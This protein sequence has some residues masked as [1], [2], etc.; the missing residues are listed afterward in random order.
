[1]KDIELLPCPF[2][3]GKADIIMDSRTY[4]MNPN[5]KVNAY[6]P[7]CRNRNCIIYNLGS[8]IIYET[9]VEAANAWNTRKGAGEG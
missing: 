8:G 3:G 5:M 7:V 2:C 1:M 6:E 9:P 4:I